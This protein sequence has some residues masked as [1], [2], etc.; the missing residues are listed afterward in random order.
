MD[1]AEAGFR[2]GVTGPRDGAFDVDV[3]SVEAWG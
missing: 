1:E 2:G 3:F